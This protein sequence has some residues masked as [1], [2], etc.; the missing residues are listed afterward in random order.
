MAQFGC[1]GSR[2]TCRVT[3]GPGVTVTG[4]GS[5]SAPYVIGAT[6]GGTTTCDQ[7]RPCLSAGEGVAYDPATGVVAVRPSADAGNVLE[8]GTDGGLLVP[9]PD[10]LSTGCGL[11][12]D[13]SA[14]APLAVASG[15]WPY[16]CDITAQGGVI[17][18]GPDGVLRGEPRS[19]A[20]FFSQF[21]DEDFAD[22]PVPAGS[23]V[24]VRR[25]EFPFTNPDPCNPSQVVVFEELEV[26][27]TLPPG[28]GAE[29]GFDGPDEMI[30]YR[31]TGTSTAT[32]LHFQVT[33]VRGGGI[34]QP[35]ATVTLGFDVLMGRGTAGATYTHIQG[36]VRALFITR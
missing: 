22:V 1:G 11:T 29:Y 3:A 4:N 20:Q 32:G 18:C 9:A 30:Y 8:V 10:A 23:N 31:N 21:Y 13:G 5:S 6:G 28:G 2:C 16:A 17:A 34:I 33:K 26:E 19:H 25:V 27:L 15:A 14:A 35:G 12:G 24:L 7:V 36:I